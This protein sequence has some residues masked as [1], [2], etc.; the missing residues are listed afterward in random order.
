MQTIFSM[1]MRIEGFPKP[2]AADDQS[3]AGGTLWTY[4][5][6]SNLSILFL[7]SLNVPLA[8]DWKSTV[9]SALLSTESSDSNRSHSNWDSQEFLRIDD[10]VKFA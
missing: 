1:R 4:F 5:T 3:G 2:M 6:N 7:S 8:Y 10:A 9:M